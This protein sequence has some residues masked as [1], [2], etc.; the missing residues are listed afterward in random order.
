MPRVFTQA[1]QD[2]IDKQFGGEPLV[3]VEIAWDGTN[4]TAYSDRKLNGE[5][6]PYPLVNT[7][8]SF[9]T[10]QIVTGSSDSQ[11]VNLT[12]NDIDG[13]L[14]GIVDTQDIHLRPIRVYLGFQ[15]LPFAAKALMFEGVL[16]SPYTWDEAGRTLSFSV[17]AKNEDSEAGFT[18]EDGDFP[19]VPP[20]ER[21]KAWPLVFGQ[22]C[23]MEAVQVTALRKG[24]LAQGVGVPDPTL[25][26][27]LCQAN[28]L[29]CALVTVSTRLELT[30]EQ[31]TARAEA[32]NAFSTTPALIGLAVTNPTEAQAQVATFTENYDNQFNVR[33]QKEDQQCIDRRFAE[34]CEIIQEKSQQEA[35]V[36]NPFTVR[37]GEDFPQNEEIT[38][39]IGEVQFVGVMTGE[40]FLVTYTIHP[41]SLTIDNPICKDINDSSIGFRF[42]A[43]DERPAT[44]EECL[45]GGTT[46]GEDVVN[47]SGESWR[48]YETF[49]AG[50]FIW[51]PPGTDVFLANESTIVNIVSLLPGT[52]DQVAAYRTYGDTSL[53]TEVD[54]TLY[55]VVTSD[56][57]GYTVVEIDLDSPLSTIQDEVWDDE[58]YVS[59]TSSIGPNPADII[60]WLVNKYTDYTIDATS[61]AATHTS[62]TN[63][64]SNF[65]IKAKPS[66]FTLIRDIAFQA[67]CSVFVRDNVVYL[68]YM[69]KEPTSIKTL[70]EDDILVGTFS[71]THTD[72]EDLE[73]R[74]TISWSEGEAGVNKDDETDFEFVVKHNIPKYG[75]FDADYDYYTLNIFELVE[76]SA[77][78]WAIQKSN[79]WRIVEFETPLLH[80]N[81]DVFDCVTLNIAQ[82]PT[83]KVVIKE[84]KYNVDTNTIKFTAWTP[85]LSGT[86]EAAT[87]AWPS[88]QA[89]LTPHPLDGASGESGDGNNFQVIP[90]V[91]HP[92]YAGYDPDTAVLATDGDKQPS[93]LGDTL[94]TLVCKLAT[95][96]EIADD[97]EPIIRIQEPLANKNFEDKLDGIEAEN[98]AGG[99]AGGGDDDEERNACGDSG[100]ANGGCLYEVT[101]TYVT[102]KT[103]TTRK[104]IGSNCFDA[105]PCAENSS[106]RPCESSLTTMCHSFGALFAASSFQSQK[107]AEA[108][109]LFDNCAYVTGTTAVWNAGGI[110]GIEGSGPAGFSECEDVAT[111]PGNPDAPGADAGETHQPVAQ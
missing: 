8:G 98:L 41:D 32:I 53:L 13:S 15:G 56:F 74:H 43:G 58:L 20:S 97:V 36:V 68:Q 30:P 31:Q 92:L 106:G 107:A 52:V 70:T 79:T 26:E 45:N 63:Y 39:K 11:S 83:V 75:I 28:K 93:D 57:G 23:N 49:E 6:Y 67:R 27:R 55:T 14:R 72:T 84:A 25:D 96:A 16:N 77:T 62:L 85:V 4:F 29:Q 109:A 47:G 89:A 10:T 108:K 18:M 48:Y 99:A 111:A 64:P 110:T 54:P 82:F 73:T 40:S 69:S 12:L 33:N 95:G 7:I 51:L 80:L 65:F 42:K 37:G 44:L 101:I 87:W 66:V 105:G 60:E 46:F 24:F 19:Y 59:F 35:H 100:P 17:F 88:Q 1:V 22:V 94:P 50:D 104:T 21:N 3:I 34:I 61:F 86:N 76:K 91:D 78:Y 38:I 9:D 102:P 103:V 5:D 71:F 90:P 2:E 81:L